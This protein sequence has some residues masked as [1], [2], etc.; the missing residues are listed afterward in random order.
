M[1]LSFQ[2]RPKYRKSS[3][4]RSKYTV[5]RTEQYGWFTTPYTRLMWP[6]FFFPALNSPLLF[7]VKILPYYLRVFKSYMEKWKLQMPSASA[8]VVRK[9]KRK[10]ETKQQQRNSS[11]LWNDPIEVV[12]LTINIDLNPGSYLPPV[13]RTA[14]SLPFE[15]AV[16]HRRPGYESYFENF[17]FQDPSYNSERRQRNP[18]LTYIVR[19]LVSSTLFSTEKRRG[20]PSRRQRYDNLLAAQVLLR[21]RQRRCV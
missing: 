18:L 20:P 10:T 21:F 1:K 12:F 14:A 4:V 5:P 7:R 3:V 13:L 2:S 15:S 11:D 17:N 16:S 8:L 9:V 19:K 6:S